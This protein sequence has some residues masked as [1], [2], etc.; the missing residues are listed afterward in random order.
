MRIIIC[1]DDQ[2]W[3]KIIKEYILSNLD[4]YS[5]SVVITC[6]SARE[7]DE[8]CCKN[9][10]DV[11]FLDIEL[12]DMNGIQLAKQLR[13][14]FSTLIIVY[15]TNHPQYVFTCFETEP[16]YFLRKPVKKA[17]FDRVFQIIIKKH[18]ELH[19]CIPIKWQNDSV[20]LEIKE[21][22]YIEGYNRHLIFHLYNYERYEVVGK[23]NDIYNSL[24]IHGFVKTHQ[25]FIVNMLHIKE[26]GENEVRMKNG[27][28][29]LMSVRKRLKTKEAYSNY[30]NRRFK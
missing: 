30:I 2:R 27:E 13:K 8:Y 29:V 19:K 14:K 26:F 25:G 21:I 18:T 24:K 10:P 6:N 16:L 12:G 4:E 11:I 9:E 20:N 5:E 15:I 23:L 1:D 28:A 17:E 3:C 22:C 7:T